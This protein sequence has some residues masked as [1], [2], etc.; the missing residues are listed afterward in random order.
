MR[1]QEA[2]SQEATYYRTA[3]LLGL[4]RGEGVH[5]WAHQVIEQEAD[6]PQAFFEI[7][8]VPADDLSGLR[9]AL[10][11]LVIEPEPPAV[12][13]A[14]FGRLH[15]DLATDRRGFGDTLTVVRQIR[16]MLRLPR[17]MYAA[18][19]AALVAQAQDPQGTALVRWLQGFAGSGVSKLR[20][21]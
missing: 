13:E 16:S 19:N 21:G 1:T 14:I 9:Y 5:E 7:I 10:W 11:P 12:L 6:P 20:P 15:E 17:V 4:I 2:H 3:L 18:L 8:S